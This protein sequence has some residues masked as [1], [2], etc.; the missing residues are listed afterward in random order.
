[1]DSKKETSTFPKDENVLEQDESQKI[2]NEGLQEIQSWSNVVSNSLLGKEECNFSLDL[3]TFKKFLQKM[4]VS[5][6]FPLT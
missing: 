2:K 5:F 6:A 3:I 1:M 4:T